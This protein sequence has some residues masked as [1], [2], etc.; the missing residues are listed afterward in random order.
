MRL[1]TLKNIEEDIV[2]AHD[3]YVNCYSIKLVEFDTFVGVVQAIRKL[4]L[5]VLMLSVEVLHG[6]N[7]F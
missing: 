1:I 7:G 6:K 3:L 5:T 2:K 4:K